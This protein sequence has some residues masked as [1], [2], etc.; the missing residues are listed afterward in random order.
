[1]TESR[2][3]ASD[4]GNLPGKRRCHRVIHSDGMASIKSKV[5]ASSDG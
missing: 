3:S 5:I 4:D 2:R 1:M